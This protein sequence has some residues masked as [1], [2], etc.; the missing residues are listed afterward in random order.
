MP[1]KQPP[2]TAAMQRLPRYLAY[3]RVKQKQGVTAVSSTS[4]AEDLRLYPVQVRKDLALATDAGRP[5]MG[6]PLDVLIEDLERY[7]GYHNTR[8]AFVIGAGR[9]GQALLGHRQFQDC[10]LSILAGF[11]VN[12][13]LYGVEI[14]GKP[15]FP[16]EKLSN[17]VSRMRVRV[18]ILT[19]PDAVAQRVCDESVAC[20]I[21]ALWNFTNVQLDVPDHIVV[22]E[23]NLSA[24]FAILTNR[25]ETVLSH[26]APSKD[27]PPPPTGKKKE[28]TAHEHHDRKI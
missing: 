22:Q 7:L 11:D 26:H 21:R 15:I 10:G 16:M 9:L 3:L 6:Y 4:I 17:L 28:D 23:E 19:V 14:E 20:G 2:V 12:P 27:W 5:K 18:G 25:L 13:S 8:D 24:S 1:A